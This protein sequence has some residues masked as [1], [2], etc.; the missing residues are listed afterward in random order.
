MSAVDEAKLCL[1]S[2]DGGGVRGLSTL[3]ILKV[4]MDS[5]NNEREN[6]GLPPVKP[7]EIF[8]L[9]GGTSTGGLIAIMLGRLQMNVDECILEYKNIM[10]AVFEKNS[11]WLP[12]SWTGKVKARFDPTR[13]E[14]AIKGVITREGASKTDLLNDG[15]IRDCKV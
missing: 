2:L 9:I 10:K 15:N 5:L 13:L 7:C 11:G 4:L 3:Y 14:D 6:D 12:I 8:D 1:L